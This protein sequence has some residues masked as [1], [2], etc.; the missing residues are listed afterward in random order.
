MAALNISL[1]NQMMMNGTLNLSDLA[2]I[3]AVDTQQQARMIDE[4][5]ATPG[6]DSSHID[7][8]TQ[9]EVQDSA[10]FNLQQTTTTINNNDPHSTKTTC[11]R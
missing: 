7:D 8:E 2:S 4:V 3:G 10:S 6:S 5:A 1:L 9:S 11:F